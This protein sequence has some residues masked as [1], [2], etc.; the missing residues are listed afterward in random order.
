[1]LA[2]SYNLNTQKV[3]TGG[4]GASRPPKAMYKV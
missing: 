4:S 1:M 2:H 3:E